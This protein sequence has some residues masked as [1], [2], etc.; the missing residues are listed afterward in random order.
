MLCKIW[1]FHGGD[2]DECRLLGYKKPVLTSEEAHYFSGR[3]PSRLMLCKIWGFYG[4]DYE[5]RRLLGYKKP[6]R[7]LQETHYISVTKLSRLMM[8]KISGFHGGDSVKC[9]PSSMFYF[10]LPGNNDSLCANLINTTSYVV[11]FLGCWL[12]FEGSG[13]ISSTWLYDRILFAGCC[14]GS[15]CIYS[16]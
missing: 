10:L 15:M 9:S 3:E 11:L 16:A 14:L 13:L 5:E 1:G 2:Y 6:V 4:G 7:T 12:L 8:C